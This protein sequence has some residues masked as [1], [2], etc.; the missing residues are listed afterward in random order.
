MFLWKKKFKVNC[1]PESYLDFWQDRIVELAPEVALGGVCVLNF[2]VFPK[3]IESKL[4]YSIRKSCIDAEVLDEW[5][6]FVR[7]CLSSRAES[8]SAL[9]E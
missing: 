9:F 3:E 1:D 6:Y 4:K 2:D 7:E 8:D 5:I